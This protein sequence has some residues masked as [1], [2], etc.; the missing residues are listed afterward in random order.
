M[1]DPEDREAAD[2]IRRHGPAPCRSRN[3]DTPRYLP[4]LRC[5]ASNVV[6]EERRGG[7]LL[8][9][10]EVKGSASKID[11]IDV[12]LLAMAPVIAEEAEPASLAPL[13]CLADAL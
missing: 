10:K 8:P 9:V 3:V 12:L 13:A 6:A 11:G 7:S 2:G 1:N 4:C 5:M